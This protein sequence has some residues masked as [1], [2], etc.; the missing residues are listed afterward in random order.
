MSPY[1]R[2]VSNWWWLERRP[3]TLFILREITS[4][5]VAGY[6]VF[7]VYLLYQ[8]G[9]GPQGY[10]AVLEALR[11]PLS[12]ALHVV[13][14][15]FVLY[16]TVTWFNL[17]PKVMVVRIGEERLSPVLIAGAVYAGWIVVS[18]AIAWLIFGA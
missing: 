13:A 5:F 9:Q 4:V 2:P 11:S 7:L 14:L 18:L 1:V 15:L 8:L 16:H 10:A 17:T 12:I 3:Y 6:C